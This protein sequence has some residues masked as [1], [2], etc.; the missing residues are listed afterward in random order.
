MIGSLES[1]VQPCSRLMP[2]SRRRSCV[3]SGDG[4]WE[5]VLDVH[6]AHCRQVDLDRLRLERVGELG[7]E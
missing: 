7:G 5:T 1:V 4:V 2:L 3:A 6:V